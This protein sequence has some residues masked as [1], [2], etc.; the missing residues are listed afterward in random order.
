MSVELF[1]E[2]EAFENLA[3]FVGTLFAFN[4]DDGQWSWKRLVRVETSLAD[5]SPLGT[6]TAAELHALAMDGYDPKTTP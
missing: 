6:L 4:D 5:G 1:H 3:Q 2:A